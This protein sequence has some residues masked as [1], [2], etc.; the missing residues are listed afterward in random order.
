MSVYVIVCVGLT[1][2]EVPLT[3]PTPWLMLV[4]DAPVTDQ[5]SCVEEPSAIV[6]G[7]ATNELMTGFAGGGGGGGWFTVTVRLEVAEPWG[8]VAVRV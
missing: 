1:L 5:M 4:E 3:T 2:T 8:L 6:E 7:F